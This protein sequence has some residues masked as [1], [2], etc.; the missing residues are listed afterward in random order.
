LLHWGLGDQKGKC[1]L[2]FG[3]SLKDHA[4]AK[5]GMSIEVKVK[6]KTEL[7]QFIEL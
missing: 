2:K 7:R 5:F 4:E 6:R 3:L 1:V